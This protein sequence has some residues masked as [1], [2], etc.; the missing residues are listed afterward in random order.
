M[1]SIATFRHNHWIGYHVPMYLRV[2]ES[3]KKHRYIAKEQVRK[4]GERMGRIG[5][6]G[7]LRGTG[8]QPS[9]FRDWSG[10]CWL[11]QL[12][13]GEDSESLLGGAGWRDA[14]PLSQVFD[15]FSSQ[16]FISKPSKL[17]W[18]F[19]QTLRIIHTLNIHQSLLENK[20]KN[21]NPSQ[22]NSNNTTHKDSNELH[23]EFKGFTFESNKLC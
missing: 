15:D 10:V 11:A 6:P 18:F 7:A 12:I 2:L 3:T 13:K 1:G 22:E 20:T 17:N 9:T 16:F 21:M 14:P 23:Q 8:S 5:V 4:D 19:P